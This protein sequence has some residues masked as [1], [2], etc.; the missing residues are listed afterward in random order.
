MTTRASL[1]KL[2]A[3]SFLTYVPLKTGLDIALWGW[4][5]LRRAALVQLAVLPLAQ[6]IV[7]WLVLR[8]GGIRKPD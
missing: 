2:C 5:D 7:L 4:V 6:G 8:P 3:V 1:L